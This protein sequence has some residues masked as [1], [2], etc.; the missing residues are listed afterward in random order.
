[1]DVTCADV[2]VRLK[3]QMSVLGSCMSLSPC[4]ECFSEVSHMCCQVP[5]SCYPYTS[6]QALKKAQKISTYVKVLFI[7]K[8]TIVPI[9][10][11]LNNAPCTKRSFESSRL[12]IFSDPSSLLGSVFLTSTKSSGDNRT[13]PKSFRDIAD[14]QARAR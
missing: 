5:N 14:S 13:V 1:M 9:L 10:I 12:R 11:D 7:F 4:I 2:R 6:V 8:V 3:G